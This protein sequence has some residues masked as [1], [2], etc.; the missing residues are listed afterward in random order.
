MWPPGL[1]FNVTCTICRTGS[2]SRALGARRDID[3]QIRGRLC[4]FIFPKVLRGALGAQ[5]VE[6]KNKQNPTYIA[7]TGRPDPPPKPLGGG[8]GAKNKIK[9]A[10]NTDGVCA[11]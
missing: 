5:L 4:L 3:Q 6:P 9:I 2:V 8:E 1:I 11:K 7:R 10:L